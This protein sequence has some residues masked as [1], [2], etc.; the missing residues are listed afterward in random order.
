MQSY[1]TFSVGGTLAV[2]AHGITTDYCFAESVLEFRLARVNSNGKAEVVTC[3]RPEPGETT[4]NDEFSLGNELFGLVL[5]GYGMF[6]VI[7][8]V[9]LK[10]EDN[11]HLE[12]D[13][14]QLNIHS[15]DSSGS[16]DE[17]GNRCDFVRIYDN[18]RQSA[19]NG[20]S[21]LENSDT[22]L[23]TVEIKMARLNTINLSKVSLYVLRRS[24][25]TATMSDLPAAPKEMSPTSQLLYKWILP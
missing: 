5:G 2:N 21:N 8:E 14:M 13:S 1:C 4:R 25:H 9:V 3:C 10:I 19:H 11:V 20:K 12:L 23:G 17:K 24:S 6:G 18:C 15:M 16:D 22:S 7:T